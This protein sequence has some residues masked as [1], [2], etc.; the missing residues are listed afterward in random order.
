MKD[1]SFTSSGAHHFKMPRAR[2]D[3]AALYAVID[4]KCK[5]CTSCGRRELCTR[6]DPLARPVLGPGS[7]RV[8]PSMKMMIII[9][10]PHHHPVVVVVVVV[11]C[12]WLFRLL[13]PRRCLRVRRYL[14]THNSIN[15]QW[16]LPLPFD[17]ESGAS[18]Y[19]AGGGGNTSWRLVWK[20][21]FWGSRSD[22]PIMS[23][24]L[25]P[26]PGPTPWAWPLA[27]VQQYMN[28]V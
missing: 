14:C 25:S 7:V 18:P 15:N 3:N 22:A 23:R 1:H 5:K 27:W 9:A 12:R 16:R 6:A 19:P 17:P 24:G 2:E 10:S 20:V 13:G 28:T 26:G 8:P 11:H 4:H 21:D